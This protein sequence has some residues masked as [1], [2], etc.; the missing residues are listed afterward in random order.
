MAPSPDKTLRILRWP[1][2]KDMTGYQSKTHVERLEKK[3]LF[4]SS[5]KIGPRAKGW[6]ESEV[7]EWIEER[8]AES[9]SGNAA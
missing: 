6:L 8:I 1:A 2:V 4:P 9:R 5:I 7:R 3:G